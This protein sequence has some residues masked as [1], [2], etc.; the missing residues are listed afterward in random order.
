MD[1]LGHVMFFI[2]GSRDYKFSN[3]ALA[4]QQTRESQSFISLVL[5]PDLL[6]AVTFSCHPY[7]LYP[8]SLSL[9]TASQVGRVPFFFKPL[10][11]YVTPQKTKSSL[12]HLEVPPSFPYFCRHSHTSL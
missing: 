3:T 11:L 7:S 5:L 6:R 8:I 12:H 9:R 1:F 2:R 10:P 4:A